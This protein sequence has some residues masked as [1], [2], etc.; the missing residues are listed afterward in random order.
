[1]NSQAMIVM[2]CFNEEENLSATCHSLGFG[3]GNSDKCLDAILII[4]DNNSTDLTGDISYEIQQVSPKGQVHIVRENEQ[5]YV[6]A[7]NAGNQFAILLGLQLS[8]KIEDILIFQVDADTTY[9][10]RYVEIMQSFANSQGRNFIFEACVNYTPVFR[11]SNIDYI[12]LLEGI[13]ARYEKL[14]SHQR[15]YI[16]DDKVVAYWLDDYVTW[17]GHIREFSS[18][19]EEIYAETTRLFLKAL[20][21]GAARKKVESVTAFHSERKILEDPTLGFATA[22]FPRESSWIREWTEKKHQADLV[23]DTDFKDASCFRILHLI[24]LFYLLPLHVDRSLMNGIVPNLRPL[25]KYFLGL[26]PTRT[27]SDLQSRPGIFLSDVFTT[28]KDYPDAIVEK[29][30]DVLNKICQCQQR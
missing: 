8:L 4:V 6:P 28:L 29:S 7:R 18:A 17:G 24:A 10:D 23:S 15:D 30:D 22:G 27:L 12:Y 26:I 19:G 9:P 14:Y 16:V 5:G 11:Q 20:T 2:P 13:D 1:M 3:L 25:E 21:H